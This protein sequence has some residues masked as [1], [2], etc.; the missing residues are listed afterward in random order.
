MNPPVIAHP[1]PRHIP[2]DD[3]PNVPDLCPLDSAQARR[4]ARLPVV[5][6]PAEVRELRDWLRTA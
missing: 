1:T 4:A 3:L 6:T 2:D 5:I